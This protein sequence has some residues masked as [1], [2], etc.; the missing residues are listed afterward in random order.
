MAYQ[1]T[2]RDLA[3]RAYRERGDRRR[4]FEEAEKV[5]IKNNT[6]Y[7]CPIWRDCSFIRER[8]GEIDVSLGLCYYPTKD[9]SEIE[10]DVCLGKDFPQYAGCNYYKTQ[11]LARERRLGNIENE[12]EVGRLLVKTIGEIRERAEEESK[13]FNKMI[14]NE[15]KEAWQKASERGTWREL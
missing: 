12:I 5:D 13:R 8:L 2:N 7:V 15:L 11:T 10:M 6:M 14:D 3:E 4:D 9:P 1:Y